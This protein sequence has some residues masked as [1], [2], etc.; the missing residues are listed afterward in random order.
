VSKLSQDCGPSG[1]TCPPSDQSVINRG[2]VEDA[3]AVTFWAIGGAAVLTGGGLW[4]VG[5]ASASEKTAVRLEPIVGARGGGL[6]L[7]GP[8]W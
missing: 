2:K 1:Q 8:L 4:L 6:W 7:T 3:L 5:G